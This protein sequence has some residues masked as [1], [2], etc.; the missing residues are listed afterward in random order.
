MNTQYYRSKVLCLEWPSFS[1]EGFS[2]CW[3][4]DLHIAPSGFCVSKFIKG[5]EKNIFSFW[6][7]GF[8]FLLPHPMIVLIL[9][10]CFIDMTMTVSFFCSWA[11]FENLIVPSSFLSNHYLLSPFN[12]NYK[13]ITEPSGFLGKDVW[14][15]T[16]VPAELV[17]FFEG[18]A[19]VS[20]QPLVF[21]V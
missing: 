8:L 9:L 1:N 6:N 10:C 16:D 12:W 21:S 17:A 7:S 18:F 13:L 20:S 2:F 14:L 3:Y 15:D 19:V 4:S 5:E 11:L